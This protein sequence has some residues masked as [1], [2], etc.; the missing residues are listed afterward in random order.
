M[1]DYDAYNSFFE[2]VDLMYAKL[3][4]P[5]LLIIFTYKFVTVLFN[6]CTGHGFS[7]IGSGHF[8]FHKRVLA[9]KETATPLSE[10]E[11]KHNERHIKS[12]PNLGANLNA[13]RSSGSKPKR[14]GK[15]S[16]FWEKHNK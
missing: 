3:A 16:A 7:L 15:N 10:S 5:F 14:G 4:V 2:S 9:V 6:V 1:S 8:G 13:S 11:I 12:R